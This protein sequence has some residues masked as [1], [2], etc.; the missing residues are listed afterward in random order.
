MLLDETRI[1][2]YSITF[3]L[4]PYLKTPC[5][6]VVN[7]LFVCPPVYP[8]NDIYNGM[9]ITMVILRVL[10]FFKDV[11]VIKINNFF[12]QGTLGMKTIH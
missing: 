3:N 8:P 1:W 12:P 6:N 5:H 4:G 9:N 10:S 2:V 11:Q 7:G